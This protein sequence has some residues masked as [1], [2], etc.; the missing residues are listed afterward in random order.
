M[1]GSEN[2]DVMFAHLRVSAVNS[3]SWLTVP[4]AL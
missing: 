3:V 1:S 2:K 4:A